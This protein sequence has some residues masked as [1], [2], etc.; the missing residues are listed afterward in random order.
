MLAVIIL[1][2]KFFE[3]VKKLEKIGLDKLRPMTLFVAIFDSNLF[4][5]VFY[6]CFQIVRDFS[7][8]MTDKSILASV[9]LL[10]FL[11]FFYSFSGYFFL[12]ISDHITAENSLTFSKFKSRGLVIEMIIM[13]TVKCAKAVVHSLLIQYYEAQIV[14]LC[15]LDLFTLFAILYYRKYFINYKFFSAF[16]SYYVV[17]FTINCTFFIKYKFY[18]TDLDFEYICNIIVIVA[19][20]FLV[21][22]T[23]M[24]ILL[25]L[26]QEMSECFM[27][28]YNHLFGEKIEK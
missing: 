3:M 16:L 20:L 14:S 8:N 19:L 10:A 9:S 23:L 25:T 4:I 24:K 28:I 1:L 18:R 17:L 12:K 15:V 2:G 5:L 21:L 22:I 11:F 7:F 13:L 27:F 6:L 26:H